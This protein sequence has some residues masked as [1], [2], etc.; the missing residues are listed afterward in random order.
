MMPSFSRLASII[1]TSRKGSPLIS[2]RLSLS[3]PRF[4]LMSLHSP[5]YFSSRSLSWPNFS[6]SAWSRL[7]PRSAR[8]PGKSCAARAWRDTRGSAIFSAVSRLHPALRLSSMR[9]GRANTGRP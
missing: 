7:F 6:R 2:C 8:L 5:E 9:P 3:A 4:A 1:S